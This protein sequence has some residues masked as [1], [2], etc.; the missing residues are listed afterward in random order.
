VV[1]G[2][3]APVLPTVTTE[4]E[5]DVCW[6]VDRPLE[7]GSRWLLKHH[8][9]TVR[10][11][12]VSVEHRLD[13]DA[14]VARPAAALELND[15]GRVRLRLAAPVVADRYHEQHEGGRFVLIDEASNDTAA[16]GMIRSFDP[17]PAS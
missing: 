15:L 10:A 14:L 7:A 16:A 13:L 17:S 2:V 12:A 1:V 4:L 5:A 8:T 3:A 9:S 11:T 6:L